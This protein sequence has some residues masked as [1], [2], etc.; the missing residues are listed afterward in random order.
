[1]NNLD[2][3]AYLTPESI[4]AR[5]C[6]EKTISVEKLK[7]ITRYPNCDSQHEIVARF[8]RAFE[9]FSPEQRSMYLKFVWGRNRLPID[10]SQV[11]KHEIRLME[12]MNETGFPQS[13]TCFFSLDIPF[14]R[15]DEICRKRL[16]QAAEMCG[17]VDTD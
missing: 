13:H 6:G 4:E 8:W 5:V 10:T 11:R 16:L 15:S 7:D 9:S 2:Q 1:M 12:H 17:S 14:Y 3:I